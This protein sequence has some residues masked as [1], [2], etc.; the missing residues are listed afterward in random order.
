M[1]NIKK[2]EAFLLEH[3]DYY[4]PAR[5]EHELLLVAKIRNEKGLKWTNRLTEV[6]KQEPEIEVLPKKKNILERL[7]K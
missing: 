5:F 1:K 7:F 6:Q 3:P 2:R 4:S